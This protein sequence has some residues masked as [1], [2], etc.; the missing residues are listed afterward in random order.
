MRNSIRL[1]GVRQVRLSSAHLQN[2]DR[3]LGVV[4]LI[5]CDA[6]PGPGKTLRLLDRIPN[7]VAVCLPRSFDRVK[8]HIRRV[9]TP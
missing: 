2:H 5:D 7:R 3:F 1:N 4:I 9:V 6:P 8:H